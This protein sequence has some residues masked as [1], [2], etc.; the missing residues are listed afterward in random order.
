VRIILF[1]KKIFG[2]VMFIDLFSV[3]A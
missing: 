3:C 1:F 2:N